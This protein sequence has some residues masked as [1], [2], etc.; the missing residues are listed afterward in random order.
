MAHDTHHHQQQHG[1]GHGPGH[2]DG[3]A[4]H[5]EARM[6]EMLDLD[7]E[8]L[9][10]YLDELTAWVGRHAPDAVRTV[11]D[12]G[13]GTGT[14]SLALARRFPAAEVIAVDRS[15]L[16]LERLRATAD[17]QGL[18]GRLRALAADVD[19]AW[20]RTGPVDVAWA[21]LSMHHFADP[22]RVLSDVHAALNPGGLLTVVEMDSLPRF[23]PDDLG[24]GRPGLESRCH[25][26]MPEAP[27]SQHPDWRGPLERA[28][29]EI[30]EQRVMPV[31]LDPAPAGAGR[32]ARAF[33]SGVRGAL[34]DRLGADDLA[35]LDRL[36]A[37][38]GPD[39]LVRRTDL[40]VR[41]SR[42]AWAARRRPDRPSA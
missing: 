40:A 16:M 29:F 20:P 13:A 28:G 35:T 41:G 7:A 12:I 2:Q 10:T 25:R 9:G 34:T 18:G 30:V 17:R 38:D 8:V 26:A 1:H 21:A 33:L 4:P 24:L 3:D 42:T 19:T 23:L 32:Y 27:W 37:D 22:D 15:P 11:L 6:A 14:G 5:D 39:A 36:L 31:A